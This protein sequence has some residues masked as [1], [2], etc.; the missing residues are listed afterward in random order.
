MK[1]IASAVALMGFAG[2]N[3]SAFAADA[4]SAE[5][6]EVVGSNI[7]RVA[8]EGPVPVVI[9]KKEEIQKTGASTV[10]E[11]L[12]NNGVAG[13]GSFETQSSASFVSGASAVGFRGL[14]AGDTLVLLNGRRISAYGGAQQSGS[15]GAVAFV[16]LNSLPL[17]AVEQIQILKD[18]ASAV[19]GADAIAGVLNIITRKD[20]QGFETNF[21]VGAYGDAGGAETK[22][23]AT[24]GFGSLAD[25]R[26]NVM[27][28]LEGSK[29]DAIYFRDRDLTKSFD[30]RSQFASGYDGR[31]GYSDFGN[32][33]TSA[34]GTP[35]AGPNCPAEF[36]R[37]G[38]CRYDFGRVEQLQPEQTRVGGLLVGTFAI[39][40]DIKAFSELAFNRNKTKV[41]GRASALGTEN[42]FLSVD[43]VRGLA[44]G[45]TGNAVATALAQH[46][47]A[48]YFSGNPDKVYMNTRITEYG[49]RNDEI[50]TDATRA[51]IGLK[52]NFM[53]WSWET[54]LT[55]S[56]TKVETINNNEIRKDVLA[57]LIVNGTA[58]IYG[59]QKTG[60]DSARYIGWDHSE[61]KLTMF[62]FKLSGEV[63]QLPAGALAMAFGGEARKEEMSSTADPI[64]TAG[65]KTGSASTN[66]NGD[67]NLNSAFL[68]FNVPVLDSLELQLATRYDHYSDF[69]STSNPKIA[70]RWQP[71]KSFLVR[72]SY[73]TAFKAPTLFQLYEAQQA[74]GFNDYVDTARCNAGIATDCDTRLIEVRSG[75]SVAA[76]YQLKP[77]ESKNYNLG[78][79][80]EPTANIN[81][82]IDFWRIKK[83]NAITQ[84]DVQTLID[85]NSPNVIRNPS[86]DG[87]PGAIIYVRNSYYNAYRQDL[88]GVDFELNGKWTLPNGAKFAPGLSLT[89]TNKFKQ[90]SADGTEVV[91][92][93][94]NNFYYVAVPR[95]KGQG[96]FDYSQGIWNVASQL[97]YTSSYSADYQGAG[98]A[99]AQT[100]VAS[101]TTVDSQVG[102]RGLKNTELRFGIRNLFNREAVYVAG[103]AA[104]TDTAMYDARGRFYY[105][106][107]NYKFW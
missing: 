73:G 95:L 54:A 15:D 27:L 106:S 23:S 100:K 59:N 41:E 43:S 42:D 96:R 51:L 48:G 94:G 98:A 18:G 1:K 58:N 80:W 3:A 67:R 46:A 78:F 47:P 40:P 63:L 13:G 2:F 7:K 16:D 5:K 8:K 77:E 22:A 72:A 20:Y 12:K 65:L 17:S 84:N 105:A 81:T 76:G 92:Q 52:G 57:D 36:I 37:A 4:A 6:I 44:A 102:Y 31:S 75:G 74:G 88:S 93:V 82:S 28:S 64:S 71:S 34:G 107:V 50:T 14:S 55:Q 79:V 83:T 26:Y 90:W 62:D 49:P 10:S 21:R 11:L 103:Y 86:V 60:L 104:G 25:D 89:Y 29:T 61:S 33:Y 101:F 87:V 85:N 66:T 19:Y 97:N 91:N 9:L 53:D 39:T 32:Y 35:K 38:V 45:T 99:E 24:I 30:H 70:L 56:K 69:G 68:E